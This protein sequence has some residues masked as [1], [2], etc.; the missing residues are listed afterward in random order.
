MGRLIKTYLYRLAKD[1][2]YY[3][4]IG[5]TLLASI[6]TTVIY[7]EL[8]AYALGHGGT[9]A[10]VSISNLL[11]S[12]ASIGQYPL[13][14]ATAYVSFFFSAEWKNGTLRNQILSGQSRT[15][16]FY[17]AILSGA[18]ITTLAWAVYFLIALVLGAATQM[19]FLV[20][21]QEGLAV[22]ISLIMN[23]FLNLFITVIAVTMSF[24]VT[25]AWGAFGLLVLFFAVSGIINGIS[26]ITGY[27]NNDNYYIFNEFLYDYQETIWNFSSTS[28]IFGGY[29]ADM[30][31]A[32]LDSL[33]YSTGRISSSGDL[34]TITVTGRFVPL[35]LKTLFFDTFIGGGISYLGCLC[36]KKR[37]IK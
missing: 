2:V 36:F 24:F 28:S 6:I 7:A 16:I 35:L 22:F 32:K 34:Q 29:A 3:V 10:V 27:L 17:S 5:L 21:G 14:L 20:T 26:S 15:K 13:V 4:I 19:P 11:L 18:I 30:T 1:P 12:G 8:N 37:N 25:N 9:S 23:V 33:T 31:M